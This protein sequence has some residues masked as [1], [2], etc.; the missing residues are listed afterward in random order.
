MVKEGLTNGCKKFM[1]L[2]P[3]NNF[4]N[5]VM[6]DGYFY[7]SLCGIYGKEQVDKEIERL[8]FEKI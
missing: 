8:Q 7:Q 3:Y 2:P 6:G 4:C 1:G 5:I